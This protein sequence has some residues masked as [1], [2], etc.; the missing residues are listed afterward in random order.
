MLFHL[1]AFITTFFEFQTPVNTYELEIEYGSDDSESRLHPVPRVIAAYFELDKRM[2]VS[3]IRKLLE[4]LP[5]A[6]ALCGAECTV[7][8][9]K[10]PSP[11]GGEHLYLHPKTLAPGELAEAER[12]GSI[13]G[14]FPG[15]GRKPTVYVIIERGSIVKVFVHQDNGYFGRAC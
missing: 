6:A 12:I 13:F 8:G 7:A 2:S 15:R 5:E 9:D 3:D 4:D 10:E 1:Q 11:F 14:A